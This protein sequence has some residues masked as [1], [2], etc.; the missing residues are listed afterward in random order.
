MI[1]QRDNANL[2][3]ADLTDA[4]LWYANMRDANLQNA[5]MQVSDLRYASL[6]NANLK[7]VDFTN[8]SLFDAK[9]S[10]ADLTIANFQGVN[11]LHADLTGADLKGT[12]LCEAVVDSDF[13]MQEWKGTPIWEKDCFGVCGG[14]MTITKDNCGVCGGENLHNTGNC[15]CQG[16]PNGETIVDLC[17]ICGGN[18][19]GTDCNNNGILDHC[20]ESYQKGFNASTA[21]ADLNADGIENI[22]DIVQLVENVLKTNIN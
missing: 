15:D 10:G 6:V 18:G 8:A 7:S 5:S 19:D 14:D 12:L 2:E 22:L 13:K 1:L 20:E 9:L 11:L 4:W 3:N 21:R 17:G 16:I